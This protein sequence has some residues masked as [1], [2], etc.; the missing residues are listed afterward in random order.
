MPMSHR[1]SDLYFCMRPN[2][3]RNSPVKSNPL[4]RHF[5]HHRASDIRKWLR[6]R[7]RSKLK[8]SFSTKTYFYRRLVLMWLSNIHTCTL[9]TRAIWLKPARIWWIRR[10]FWLRIGKLVSFRQY[11]SL[12]NLCSIFNSLHLTTM[13]IQY[14]PTVVACFC[15]YLA[16]KWS[17]WE[18]STVIQNNQDDVVAEH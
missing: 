11:H 8:I 15:I 18:V 6:L 12:N 5:S 16:C 9:S 7:F 13:C 17:R 3:S 4:F 2:R 10:I 1:R 14:R